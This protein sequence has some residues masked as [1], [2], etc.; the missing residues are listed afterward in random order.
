[1]WQ[2]IAQ[3]ISDSLGFKFIITKKQQ[4]STSSTILIFKI[5]DQKHH[6]FVKLNKVQN[7]DQFESESL[8]LTQLT[9]D[10]LFFVPDCICSGITINHSYLVLE[11]LDIDV[12]TKTN[13]H[14]MGIVLARMHQKHQQGMHGWQQDNYIGSTVQPNKWHKKW[15]MFFSEQRIGWQLQL[16]AEKNINICGIN[17]FIE[18]VQSILHTHTPAPS[19]LH[20]D[21]WQGNIASVSGHPAIFDPACYYGDRETD[22]AM[23][24]VFGDFPAPFY[25]AYNE[26][27]PLDHN[28]S[29][30]KPI[31]QLYHILNHAN[32]FKGHYID[33]AKQIIDDIKN[34]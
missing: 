31:Y 34:L 18:I 5:S 27:Y 33:E 29:I 15:H 6:Y 14:E 13:W 21:L 19:L 3:H 32:M 26:V 23:T 2:A 8:N 24:Q 28:Y 4:L 25:D 22:I 11:W 7:Y 17:E 16:L 9:T 30:R 12:N 10:S 20:G 1:M